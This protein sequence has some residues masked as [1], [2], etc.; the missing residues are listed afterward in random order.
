MD[1]KTQIDLKIRM[2][3][4]PNPKLDLDRNSSKMI[5]RT[6][7]TKDRKSCIVINIYFLNNIVLTNAYSIKTQDKIIMR[8]IDTTY[9][10]T[11]NAIAFYY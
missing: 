11:F 8:C 2:D 10:L 6:T 9:I 1:P 4:N 7:P 3:P 5:T